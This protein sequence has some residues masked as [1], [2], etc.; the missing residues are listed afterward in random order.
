[1]RITAWRERKKKEGATLNPKTSREAKIHS[2]H[3]SKTPTNI[4]IM[5]QNASKER[6]LSL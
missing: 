6:V 5:N 2:F 3:T 1:M 4:S